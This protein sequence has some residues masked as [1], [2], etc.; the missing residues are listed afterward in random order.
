ME[1]N[2][3]K[4]IAGAMLTMS[5]LLTAC[6]SDGGKYGNLSKDEAKAEVET[7]YKK[8]DPHEAALKKDIS[9]TSLDSADEL[10]DLNKTYPYTVEGNGKVN[11]EIFAS[12]EKAGSGKDGIL[13]DIAKDFNNQNQSI[14]GE[15]ISVS[16][17]SIPSGTAVDYIASG[18]H[19]PDGYTPSNKQW[20]YILTAKGVST[21]EISDRLFGNT[22]GLLMKQSVY[23]EVSPNGTVTIDAVTKAINDG[24]LLGYTN[25]Y[26]SSTG[27]SLLS[28][29]LYSFDS[30]NPIS[31][32][33]KTA[34]QK[35]QSNIPSTFVTTSQ[36]RDAAKGGTADILS[37]SYQTYI[38]TPEFC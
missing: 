2:H 27:L 33:S 36:L 32:T 12:T 16:I 21:T 28:Q 31:D 14:D 25:P 6:S 22:S 5:V 13:N 9:L 10:P 38:N 19:V 29:L 7:Y 3:K 4:L 37:I 8:I 17:R 18:N 34:F 15:T 23:N 11:V 24:K 30:S 35:L 26:S 1:F 20:D